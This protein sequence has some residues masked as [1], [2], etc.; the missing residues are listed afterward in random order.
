VLWFEIEEC[1]R[2]DYG[3]SLIPLD[4]QGA[5]EDMFTPE[6]IAQLES[7]DPERD[8][9]V[10]FVKDLVPINLHWRRA[11]KSVRNTGSPS[12]LVQLSRNEN[13]TTKQVKV[14][15]TIHAS[16]NSFK[17]VDVSFSQAITEGE[18]KSSQNNWELLLKALGKAD[19]IWGDEF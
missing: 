19:E 6:I 8:I 11:V 9:V 2:G 7:Y 5:R 17:A 4:D 14:S 3:M 1:L 18:L 15:T 13:S 10:V 12:S 16:F